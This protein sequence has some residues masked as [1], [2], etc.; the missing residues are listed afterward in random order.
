MDWFSSPYTDVTLTGKLVQTAVL[1]ETPT[2]P[3]MEM[4][5]L[6]THPLPKGKRHVVLPGSLFLQDDF[7]TII[8]CLLVSVK[9]ICRKLGLW[10]KYY[11]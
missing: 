11:N 8:P 2:V 3:G 6:D 4:P 1:P 5:A 10:K 9:E 7:L